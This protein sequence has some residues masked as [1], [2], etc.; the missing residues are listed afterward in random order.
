MIALHLV[1]LPL[2]MRAFVE[3]ALERR[4]LD[5]PPGEGSG[6]PRDGDPGY[7]VHAALAG[8]F[9][10]SAPRPFTLPPVGQRNSADPGDQPAGE[11]NLLGYSS[12]PL[13]PLRS[14]AQLGDVDL[15]GFVRWERARS[16]TMPTNWPIGVELR[17]DLRA[18]P[19]RRRLTKAPLRTNIGDP[20][21]GRQQVLL[22]R[23][24]REFD[25]FQLAA[26]RAGE[27]DEPPPKREAVYL[28]WLEDR[29]A[30]NSD[31]PQAIELVAGSVRVDSYRSVR[32]LRR[33]IVGGKRSPS[34]L[35]RP[36]VRFRGVL[37]VTD[38]DAF[39]NLL[40]SGVGRHCGFG[41]GMMLL[42]P[43]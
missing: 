41:F 25:A 31:S 14:L 4:Y 3:W 2:D 30:P 5:P 10:K 43:A 23:P 1:Q 20:R 28:Q 37:K 26:A 7:A 42:R 29:V 27:R 39:N 21:P 9:G 15:A 40:A 35:T 13:D 11:T 6:R 12:L 34:W 32:L 19:V 17:F 16:R 24:G 8:L 38:S 36:D 22:D 33:P 18:C